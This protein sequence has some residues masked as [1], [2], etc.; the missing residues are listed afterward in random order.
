MRNRTLIASALVGLFAALGLS[1]G[2]GSHP[3]GT[4]GAACSDIGSSDEC[5]SDEVCDAIEGGD[6]YCLLRCSDHADC[7]AAE[8][9]NGVS[10]DSGKACHPKDDD[11]SDDD[12]DDDGDDGK[13]DKR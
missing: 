13:K 6:T 1:A 7:D 2:C 5:A 11:D 10:G 4:V 9:C 8:R 3:G 12:G